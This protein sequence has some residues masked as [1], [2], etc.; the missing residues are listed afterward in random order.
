M[1]RVAPRVLVVDDDLLI[2]E[3]LE[4]AFADEGWDVQVRSRGQDA[5]DLLRCWMADIIL[6]DLHM[7]DMDAALFLSSYRRRVE[8]VIPILL[9]SASAHLDH[10]AARL[11]VND[12]V[13]KPFDIDTLRTTVRQVVAQQQAGSAMCRR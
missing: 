4:L 11:G 5:L 3:V 7:P 1:I 12:A 8:R 2:C 10:H 6:L 9:L 13:A